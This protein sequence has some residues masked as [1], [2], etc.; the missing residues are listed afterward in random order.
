MSSFSWCNGRNVGTGSDVYS[1]AL[2]REISDSAGLHTFTCRPY[3]LHFSVDACLDL[4]KQAID[5]A[6]SS[7]MNRLA[8][9]PANGRSICPSIFQLLEPKTTYRSRE[10]RQLAVFSV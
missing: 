1:D 4:A 2:D 6:I 5:S 3:S 7:V 8:N 10:H 9:R